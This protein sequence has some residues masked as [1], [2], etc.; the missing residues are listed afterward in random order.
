MLDIVYGLKTNAGKSLQRV[1]RFFFGRMAKEEILVKLHFLLF[2]HCCLLSK[3]EVVKFW[4]L[5]LAKHQMK[6]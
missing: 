5:I 3:C 6:L 1:S 4:A 2:L